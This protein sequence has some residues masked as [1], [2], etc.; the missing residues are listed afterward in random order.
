VAADLGCAYTL[1]VDDHGG[2]ILRVT[3]GWV[4]LELKER[5]SIVPAGASCETR[6]VVGPGT[7]YFDD[8]SSAFREALQKVDFDPEVAAIGAALT[9]ILHD[10]R[11]RDT[12]TLWHLL[13]RVDGVDRVRVFEKMAVLTP[14]PPAV[15]REGILRL[16]GPMLESWKRALDLT[17]RGNNPFV[18]KPMAQTYLRLK[19]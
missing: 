18:P 9:L 5:E 1:E 17:W 8:A 12:L 10:A 15:T 16:D 11:P 6:P 2:G 14:P 19:N 7:P 13:S 4:A 3:S